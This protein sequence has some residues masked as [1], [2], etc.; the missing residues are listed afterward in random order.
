MNRR[1]GRLRDGVIT[2]LV[3]PFTLCAVLAMFLYGRTG[4]V[5]SADPEA[6]TV[7]APQDA[8]KV[9]EERGVR[10]RIL[11][12][13]DRNLNADRTVSAPSAENYVY[14]A[15]RNN[16]VRRIYHVIPDGSWEEVE[17]TLSSYPLVSRHRGVYRTFFEDGSSVLILRLRDVPAVKEKALVHIDAGYWDL[18]GLREI[19]A[20][21][22]RGVIT[23]DVVTVSGSPPA[24]GLREIIGALQ[25]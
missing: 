17:K 6:R 8:L 5:Y 18:N 7:A 13:F 24:E 20:L 3:V 19:A 22:K 2:L 9:W 21:L 10:G 15:I 12:L 4:R 11:F 14:L 23:G 1:P 16:L 25:R